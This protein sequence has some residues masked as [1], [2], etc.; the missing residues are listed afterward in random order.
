M[1]SPITCPTKSGLNKAIL[2]DEPIK[3]GVDPTPLVGSVLNRRKHYTLTF[4]GADIDHVC[5]RAMPLRKSPRDEIFIE[6]NIDVGRNN[7]TVK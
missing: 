3:N 2:C 5:N 6:R 7:F 4:V 1:A